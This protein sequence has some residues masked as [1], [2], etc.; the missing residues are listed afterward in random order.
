MSESEMT[1]ATNTIAK[2]TVLTGDVET[3][4]NIRIEGKMIGNLKTK[5]KAVLGDSSHMDG[6][7][8]A[9][10]AE[11][12]GNVVG[13]V[14][15]AEL[16]VLKATAVISGDIVTNKLVVESGATFNGGCKMGVSIKEIR[17]GEGQKN[18]QLRKA[19]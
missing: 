2:G 11:I 13:K 6:N 19:E 7:I 18:E 16:L 3:F 1:N 9:Q 8:I 14:E 12:M 10:N 4:G 17:I 15:V 5:S